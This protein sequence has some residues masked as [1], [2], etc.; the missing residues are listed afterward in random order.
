[1]KS[2]A[3]LTCENIGGVWVKGYHRDGK[4]VKPYCRFGKGSYHKFMKSPHYR[5]WKKEHDR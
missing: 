5:K 1:M 4:Y 2:E 3:K